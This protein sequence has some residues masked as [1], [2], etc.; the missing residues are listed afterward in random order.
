MPA[1]VLP[2]HPLNISFLLQFIRKGVFVPLVPPAAREIFQ[3]PV[4]FITGT[5]V[6]PKDTS[7]E[8]GENVCIIHLGPDF[9]WDCEGFCGEAHRRSPFTSPRRGTRSSKLTGSTSAAADKEKIILDGDNSEYA[10][11]QSMP[12]RVLSAKT[13][14]N[15]DV[16]SAFYSPTPCKLSTRGDCGVQILQLPEISIGF[17]PDRDLMTS[18]RDGKKRMFTTLYEDFCQQIERE[19][20]TCTCSDKL[21][22]KD[23]SIESST[24]EIFDNSSQFEAYSCRRYRPILA[25]YMQYTT[26]AAA[27]LNPHHELN[28]HLNC[29]VAV[30]DKEIRTTQIHKIVSDLKKK[31]YRHNSQLC[32]DL[33]SSPL[34]WKKYGAYNNQTNDFE[35]VPQWFLDPIRSKLNLQEVLSHTQMFVTLIDQQKQLCDSKQSE[36]E[37]LAT[38]IYFRYYL[39]LKK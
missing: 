8:V 16:N 14:C 17:S 7:S 1:K 32:G 11:I 24:F 21:N 12:S 28:H 33:L 22:F 27:Q 18:L 9:G 3:A 15:Q 29:P 37:F 39:R 31:I 30:R 13:T 5:T 36:R 26:P 25:S 35:F 2:F 10:A 20:I 34:A 23:F 6:P 4:P 38:W 19:K